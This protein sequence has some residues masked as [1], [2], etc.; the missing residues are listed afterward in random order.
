MSAAF[1]QALPHLGAA[2]VVVYIV[3]SVFQTF[4]LS[5]RARQIIAA[6]LFISLLVPVAEYNLTHYIRVLTGDLSIT[7]L[8][9]FSLALLKDLTPL[10][11]ISQSQL[12]EICVVIVITGLLLYPTALGLTYFDLYRFGFYPVVLGPVLFVVFAG[13]AWCGRSVTASLIA[14]CF[15][16]FSL[17]FLESDNLWDYLIDPV[18]TI[19]CLTLVIRHRNNLPKFVLSQQQIETMAA[20]TIATFLLFS[21]YLAK[22][23]E[24]SFR[25][26]FTIE[27]G[28]V[29]WCTVVVLFVTM[30]VCAKRFWRLRQVRSG[31]F[32]TVTA[33][34]TLLCLFGA[35]E[36]ISWGQRIFGIE[37]PDYLKDRN[38]QGELG[39]HNL[40]VEIDGERVKI[41]KLIFGTGLAIA[42]SIYAFIATPLYRRNARVRHFFN[43]IAAPMPRNYHIIGYLFVVATVELLIDSG[44]RGEM[45]EFAGS[46]VFAL[47][48]IYP[49]NPEIFDPKRSL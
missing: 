40:V 42:L 14:F 21:I 46:I 23:N 10:R 26:E 33:L 30:M 45:T 35:G 48:V 32:L 2:L 19:Y 31:L 27:D 11:A 9:I 29:E 37:T 7:G 18:V 25:Y 3:S 16:A 38:A 49:Y 24:P 43:H 44:K 34:L 47:N 6:A 5:Q 36:E 15:I 1:S 8:V 13:T 41:N 28:F 12:L 17:G 4:G 20:M 22:F 39:L